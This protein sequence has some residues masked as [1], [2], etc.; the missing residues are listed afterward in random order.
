MNIL[1]HTIEPDGAKPVRLQE[2]G[3]ASAGTVRDS[4]PM[5]VRG[6]GGT[7]P[8]QPAEWLKHLPVTAN[9]IAKNA[10]ARSVFCIFVSGSPTEG[11]MRPERRYEEV[12][13][14]RATDDADWRVSHGAGWVGAVRP[15][16]HCPGPY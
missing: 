10:D 16:V 2:H 6:A 12:C 9:Y 4:V 1:L 3:A 7:V 15:A 8:T 11:S 5:L 13:E 14:E